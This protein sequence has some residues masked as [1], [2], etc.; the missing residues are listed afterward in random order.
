MNK[1]ALYHDQGRTDE[2]MDIMRE[3]A[4]DSVAMSNPETFMRVNYNMFIMGGDTVA[5]RKA[6][7][8]IKTIGDRLGLL[9]MVSA[10]LAENALERGD[11]RLASHYADEAQENLSKVSKDDMRLVVLRRVAEVR[12][13]TSDRRMA[14]EAYRTYADCANEIAQAQMAGEVVRLETLTSIQEID[15]DIE[16]ERR[17]RLIVFWSVLVVVCV[18]VLATGVVFRRRYKN[19]HALKT[20]A[21]RRIR[22]AEREQMAMKLDSD[23]REKVLEEAVGK[24]N[25]LHSEGDIPEDS[26]RK[27]Q[28]ILENRTNR[29]AEK[30]GF[31][32][33]F[34]KINPAFIER[35]R[36]EGPGIGES[37]LRVASYIA[38][39]MTSKEIANEMG[40]RPESVRQTRWRLRKALSLPAG[41]D[42]DK[43][44]RELYMK[45]CQ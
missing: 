15:A 45:S 17:N 10:Y 25:A 30:V 43:Y 35:L 33:L 13:A 29:N 27:I 9:P 20:V 18:G 7:S 21:E 14:L 40:V 39:G 24:L 28:K 26:H 2:A 38:I 23:N 4:D 34:K 36:A 31:A 41:T 19:L 32:G 8:R 6:Y 11:Y 5:L 42:I 3:L 16:R 22:D 37:G 12:Y 44:I 1:G